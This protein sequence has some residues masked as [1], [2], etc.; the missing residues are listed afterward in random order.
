MK[1]DSPMDCYSHIATTSLNIQFVITVTLDGS[2]GLFLVGLSVLLLTQVLNILICT[3]YV[4]TSLNLSTCTVI[5]LSL[6]HI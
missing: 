4:Y 5:F 6:I 2:H 1:S 3:M